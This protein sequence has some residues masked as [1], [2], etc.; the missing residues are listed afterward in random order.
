MI[1]STILYGISGQCESDF[2]ILLYLRQERGWSSPSNHTLHS[3]NNRL[4]D[5]FLTLTCYLTLGLLFPAITHTVITLTHWIRTTITSSTLILVLWCGVMVM[6]LVVM[7]M[8][9]LVLLVSGFFVIT[10]R[11]RVSSPPLLT[12]VALVLPLWRASHITALS[13]SV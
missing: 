10:T 7:V 6:V 4:F 9:L 13:S 12:A 11:L 1:F 2:D 8:V 5:S 3:F